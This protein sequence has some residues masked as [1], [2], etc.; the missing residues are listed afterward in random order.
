MACGG[1]RDV[2]LL[3]GVP[4]RIDI[5]GPPPDALDLLLQWGALDIEPV[6]GGLAAILPDGVTS[7]FVAAA[8]AVA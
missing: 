3:C 7:D 2:A 5:S 6:S 1:L 8:F 4:Y